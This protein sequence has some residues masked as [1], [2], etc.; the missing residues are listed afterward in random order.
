MASS[1]RS[2][3]ILCAERTQAARIAAALSGL[4]VRVLAT[5]FG[6]TA[7]EHAVGTGLIVV[8]QTTGIEPTEVV[9]RIK[10]DQRLAATPVL[11]IA[12]SDSVDERIA[13]LEAGADD[14]MTQPIDDIELAVR[15]EV[16][17]VRTPQ[18]AASEPPTPAVDTPAE[19]PEGPRS[20]GF[21]AAHGGVGTTT[22]AVNTAVR[23]ADRGAASVALVDLDPWWG[24]VA[25]HLDLQPRSSIVD[26]AR[27]L[28]GG[29]DLEVVR[30]YG[31]T[32]PSGVTVYTS[33]A[34]PD[35]SA[36]LTQ[37]QLELV[38]EGLR[39]AFDYVVVDGGS[40]MDE[41][42]QVLLARVD[43]VVVVVSPEIP[44]VRATRMLLEQMS[45]Y[46]APTER[47]VLVLNHIF[48]ASLVKRE[49]L[50]RSLQA[51]IDV[52]VPYDALAYLKAVNE[53]IPVVIGAPNSAPAQAIRR[54]ALTLVGDQPLDRTPRA[55]G[56]ASGRKPLL[57]GLRRR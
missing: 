5:P 55:S 18:V 43:R 27:D 46:E 19:H 32:H 22:L 21:F 42:A 34:R 13:L 23:L 8:D 53:G 14:V 51:P 52:E 4:G 39:G 10:A 54:L 25:T 12:Q 26:L 15:A 24:Q 9:T 17:L 28:A 31:M 29:T 30:S 50:R 44:A 16:L 7:L 3:L 20:L 37:D 41:H 11:A 45:E 40:T 6:P 48:A 49:D 36:R 35:E 38:L 2:L 56:V 57:R 33:P 47:Q 1:E